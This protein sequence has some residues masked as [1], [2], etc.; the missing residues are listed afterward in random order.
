MRRHNISI[1]VIVTTQSIINFY[2]ASDIV[3]GMIAHI[4]KD[5]SSL[6][7]C[8]DI[9]SSVT[10]VCAY[11]VTCLLV[12]ALV[13]CPLSVWVRVAGY[14]SGLDVR[15]WYFCP[16]IV[17]FVPVDMFSTMFHPVGVL[18]TLLYITMICGHPIQSVYY[19][20][21]NPDPSL[22]PSDVLPNA[23]RETFVHMF[24]W[25]FSE[26]VSGKQL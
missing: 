1:L 3:L 13:R 17:G 20:A 6:Y 8:D 4:C 7:V 2:L 14:A 12:V 15:F 25:K 21:S 9:D 10:L 11:I 23:Q 22:T 26:I 18:S 5:P 19:V 16:H 24:N